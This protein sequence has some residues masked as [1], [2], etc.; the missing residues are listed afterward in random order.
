MKQ[1]PPSIERPATGTTSVQAAAF[2]PQEMADLFLQFTRAERHVLW[3]ID[4]LPR[5]KVHYVSPAFEALWGISA[6]ALYA[7]SRLWLGRVHADDREAVT[8]AFSRWVESPLTHAFDIEYRLVRPDGSQRWVHTLGHPPLESSSHLRRCTGIT[9]DT[10]ERKRTADALRV[11]RHRLETIAAVAPSVLCSFRRNLLGLI[12]VPYGGARVAALFGMPGT[13]LE[14]DG[15]PAWERIHPDDLP[16]INERLDESSRTLSTWRVE[17]RVRMGDG[18]VR[19]LEGHG[20]PAAEANST[21][22]WHGTLTDITERKHTE[23]ALVES[24]RQLQAVVE[25]MTEGLILAS[26]DG[27]INEWNPAALA[28]H[29]LDRAQV[30]R[31]S[32]SEAAASFEVCTLD[33]ERLPLRRWPVARLLAG[34]PLQLAEFRLRRTDIAWE[35]VMSYSGARVDDAEGHPLFALLQCSD[36]TE[37]RRMEEEVVRLNSELEKRVAERTAELQAAV[38][39]IE[40]FS[41]SVSHDLR[42]PLRALDGFSQVLIEDHG[43]LLPEEGQRY[44]GIIRSTARKMGHLIDDLLAFSRLG[45]QA[46]TRRR[47]NCPQLVLSVFETLAPQRNGRQ[48]EWHMGE[49]PDCDADLALLRQVWINLLS[50]AIKYTSQT[51]N[52][53][54]EV[55]S[56]RANG[57]TE[58][59]VRDNGAGFD[60][61]YVH[62]LFGVFE[63]L[64]RAEEFEGTGVGLAIVQRIVQRHGG[65][66]RAEGAVGRGATF[67]FTLG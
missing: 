3:V 53:I 22:L 62:K 40:A 15:S 46:L 50:N 60:M 52:A 42:A 54:I 61:Q 36:V 43:K 2:T 48:I 66:V 20:T 47:I 55:G 14:E 57:V 35:R 49:L 19:W 41:Y 64:H 10:T 27:T 59:F 45:R 30:Q 21:Y 51:A 24:Q 67:Y 32:M 11:D 63:R 18:G 58:Y 29:G 4:L 38:K 28:L 31:L 5:E 16:L 12:S 34:E 6:E 44:L 33:G 7:D 23:R 65:H 1:H 56:T 37:R 39:E 26:P 8:T 13:P 9:E 17:F 25:N